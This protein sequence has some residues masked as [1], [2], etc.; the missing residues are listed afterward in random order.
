MGKAPNFY[1]TLRDRKANLFLL[2]GLGI[3]EIAFI[4]LLSVSWH[5]WGDLII[6]TGREFWIPL[7]ILKGKL[8]YKDLFYEHGPLA[9]YLLAFLYKVGGVHINA[10]IGCGITI[11]VLMAL[12]LYKI[13]R[14]FLDEL[15]SGLAVL[16]FLF[17]FAFGSYD[18]AG[19]FNFILPY[20]FASTFFILFISSALYFFI[21]F[22]FFEKEKYLLFWSL[23]LSC[24]FFSR[25]ETTVLEWL[26]FLMVGGVFI[27]KGGHKR[28]WPWVLYLI[29]PALISLMGYFLFLF[30]TRAFAGF[31][32]SVISHTWTVANSVFNAGLMGLDRIPVNSALM[33][34]SFLV[35][36]A[37]VFLLGAG[38]CGIYSFFLNKG[39]SYLPLILGSLAIFFTFGVSRH[40]EVMNFQYRCLPLILIIGASMSFI[41]TLRLFEF[42]KNVSLLSLQL[43][44]LLTISRIFFRPTVNGYG[45]YLLVLGL[46]CYYIF[47][48][49]TVKPLFKKY[50]RNFSDIFFSVTL[51][52]YFTF[53][54]SFYWRQSFSIY[55]HKNLKV[56]TERGYIFSWDDPRGARI[57][58]VIDYLKE[59]TSSG[60]RV[61]VIPE[62]V[63]I[64]FFS[65]RENP[66]GLCNFTPLALR[67]LGEERV[68]SSFGDIEYIL[69][70][71]RT[72]Q[73]YG[74][75]RFGRDY[76]KRI[77]SW[78]LENYRLIKLIGPYPFRSDNFGIAI[79]KKAT[80]YAS[81][82]EVGY[83]MI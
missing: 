10:V 46:V 31:K 63:G 78:I 20:S 26:A 67:T 35:H 81:G 1:R 69:L 76:G 22:V 30:G 71:H 60:D 18:Y 2:A 68:I 12:L 23:S 51:A 47:L 28:R 82:V 50:L 41:K 73:E 40:Y 33:V 24:A 52:C 74:F 16:T 77:Y 9:P 66:S 17:V 7:Q 72:T 58:E 53:L 80:T 48:F 43:I 38:S 13:A 56:N 44:S 29:S 59:N 39:K 6:D 54:I 21:K 42:K 83:R 32:E 65:Q 15:T 14:F 79:F 5:R 3:I 70:V 36:L 34:K 49:V 27:L 8:L 62:G 25:I 64:N 57:R 4:Y 75:P 61:V 11:T 19:I 37:V 45:F 55:T